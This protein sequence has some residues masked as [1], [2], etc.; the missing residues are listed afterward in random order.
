MAS[1]RTDPA[2]GLLHRL[3]TFRA[4]SLSSARPVIIAVALPADLK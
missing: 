3:F 1:E 2:L 4:P